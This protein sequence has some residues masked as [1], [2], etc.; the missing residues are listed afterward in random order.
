MAGEFLVDGHNA[1]ALFNMRI[2]R[3]DGMALLAMN[4]KKGKPPANFVGFSIEYKEPGGEK[5]FALKNRLSFPD[6]DASDPNRLST[7]RSP[8]QKFRWVH[9]PRN[10]DLAGDFFYRVSPVFMNEV[11]ELSYG[12]VQEA[13][14][15][16]CRETYL[17]RLLWAAYW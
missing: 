5:F 6:A 3:G 7:L 15:Q 1:A 4:W 11:N 12:E 17:H 8:I 14:I 9:F 16:L 13:K 2:Y 10:A